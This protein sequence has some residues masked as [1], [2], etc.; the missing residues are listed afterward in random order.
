VSLLL[1]KTV[2]HLPGTVRYG[3]VEQKREEKT[4]LY[5]NTFRADAV[6]A[7][8]D[9]LSGNQKMTDKLIAVDEVAEYL[10][11]KVTTVYEWAK[12]GK[13]PAAKVGRLWRFDGGEIDRWRYD[14][15]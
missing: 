5:G 13:I 3:I 10:R 14:R 8:P 11:V 9:G 1:S 4:Q 12:E 7:A 6:R 15:K 2:E